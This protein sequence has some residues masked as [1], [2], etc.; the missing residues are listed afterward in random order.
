VGDQQLVDVAAR[1]AQP[2][3]PRV[4]HL[5]RAGLGL[6]GPDALEEAVEAGRCVLGL[7]GGDAVEQQRRLLELDRGQ[8]LLHDR[9]RLGRA[10]ERRHPRVIEVHAREPLRDRLR[11]PHASGGE[12]AVVDAMLRI[13]LLTVSDEVEQVRHHSSG[14][15]R[16]CARSSIAAGTPTRPS[17]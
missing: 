6:L 5:R 7:A 16:R 4:V 9:R 17:H 14:W 3:L 15:A 1:G 13:E 10:G 12:L 2:L 8:P 11:L